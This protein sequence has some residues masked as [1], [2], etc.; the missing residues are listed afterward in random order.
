[1][2]K[3]IT[4]G[5]YPLIRPSWAALFACPVQPLRCQVNH[6]GPGRRVRRLL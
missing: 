4:S 6:H 2:K 1:M 3:A 5:R